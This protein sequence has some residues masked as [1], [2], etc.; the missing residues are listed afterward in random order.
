[1]P[2][3]V[4]AN[5]FNS[6]RLDED[7]IE[8]TECYI[9]EDNNNTQGSQSGF[10]FLDLRRD[11]PSRYGWDSVAGAQCPDPGNG[12]GGVNDWISNYPSSDVGELPL[13]YPAPTYVCRA[14]GNR[15][16]S[17]NALADHE[18]D[19]LYFPLNRCDA[20][21]PGASGGQIASNSAEVACGDTP[22]QYDIIGFVALRL[23]AVYDP[24]DPAAI[25]S[26]GSCSIDRPMSA[27]VSYNLDAEGITQGCFS[28]APATV[29]NV[30]VRRIGGPPPN[31]V[32]C[33]GATSATC[34]WIYSGDPARTVTWYGPGPAGDNRNYRIQFD[35]QTAGACGV[36]PSGNNS[37]GC[38]VVEVV[39][40]QVGGSGPGGGDPNSNLRAIALCDPAIDGSCDPVNVP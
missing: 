3:V 30:S 7:E 39:D 31:P 23:L 14:S 24:K 25:G 4:Y 34:D 17:W 2:I 20:T 15:E 29:T 12:N 26:T 22:H 10:G 35:W 11:N 36:P 9:W 38:L 32:E 21:P 8:G 33:V 27:G 19:I 37:G 13:N 5:S 1:V 6:C 16:S 28:S 40:V 18:G